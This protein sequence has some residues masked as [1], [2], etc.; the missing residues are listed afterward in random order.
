MELPEFLEIFI[1]DQFVNS[2]MRLG[3]QERWSSIEH[4]EDDHTCCEDISL[5]SSIVSLFH[6]RGFIA[7]SSDSRLQF[8]VS[9][10]SLSISWQS[11][12]WNFEPKLAIEENIFRFQIPM[13]YANLGQVPDCSDELFGVCPTDFLFESFLAWRGNQ[14]VP[15]L[16]RAP[17]R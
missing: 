15:H 3:A 16:M 8:I 9:L 12:V 11:E 6:F 2:V 4:D 13:R 14:R 1:F 17:G 7:F 10:I 5:E